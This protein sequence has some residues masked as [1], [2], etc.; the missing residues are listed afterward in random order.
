MP[1]RLRWALASLLI[2]GLAAFAQNSA[3][4]AES[5]GDAARRIRAE[6][7][8]QHS[9]A[10]HRATSQSQAAPTQ[11]AAA[12]LSAS[13]PRPP[14]SDL[15]L[16]AL[17]AGQMPPQEILRELRA[18]GIDFHPDPEYLQK[19][20]QVEGGA[21][22]EALPE[23][24]HRAAPG[25]N[26]ADQT[27]ILASAGLAMRRQQYGNALRALQIAIQ[28]HPDTP[29]LYFLGGRIFR[30]VGDWR[31]AQQA[32]A[33]AVTLDPAFAWAHGELS[34]ALYQR[35][36][37]EPSDGTTAVREARAMLAE[38]PAS[39][40]AHKYLALAL[41]LERDYNG[42][43][44]EFGQALALNPRDSS[45]YFDVGVTRAKQQDWPGAIA[46]YQ[47]AV[48]FDPSQWNYYY[49]L[50]IA[51]KA[52]GRID[53]AILSYRKAKSLA[54]GELGIRQNLGNAYCA[55]GRAPEA[56][57]ELSDLLN[58]D[59]DWNMA[60]PCLAQALRQ[61]GKTDQ[62]EKVEQ[63]YARHKGN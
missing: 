8:K 13:S 30:Q 2:L 27:A 36:Q 18:R 58:I 23:A 31:D 55:A 16:M 41:T 6:K 43:L 53:D 22:A 20:Q 37:S 47:H 52:A 46:A 49:N 21:I 9:A 63:E 11:P 33:R 34:F 38:L 19:L 17:V 60:R 42:A 54:P 45:A 25:K 1:R 3:Q 28:S 57:A 24:E 7:Q 61:T 62:A 40:D 50:G 51:L 44:A 59:P 39:A 29:E 56:I 35:G 5:L 12:T 4:N 15:R 10:R 32:F 48:E 14:F 26:H